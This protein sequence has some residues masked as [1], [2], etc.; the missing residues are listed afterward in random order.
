[1]AAA[2]AVFAAYPDA[3]EVHVCED[4]NVFL[5]ERK[6]LAQAHCTANRL[7]APMLVSRKTAESAMR[8][9]D[10]V[11]QAKA[12]AKAKAEAEQAAAAEAEAKAKAEAEQ[13]A[14]AEAEAKAKEAEEKAK[15]EAEANAKEAEEKAKAEAE[16][17]AKVKY[18]VLAD[19]V[20]ALNNSEADL[21]GEAE[22]AGTAKAEEEAGQPAAKAAPVKKGKKK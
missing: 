10:S 15:A 4:G 16:A 1:M 9:T 20:E 8:L 14:A 17:L 5:P 18:G 12:E 21:G 3:L 22:A 19:L 6:Q 13:T 2:A 11:K 7:P